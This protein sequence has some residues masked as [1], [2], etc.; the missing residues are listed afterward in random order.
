MLKQQ[1]IVKKSK[2]GKKGKKYLDSSSG[3]KSIQYSWY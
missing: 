2:S 3:N 1:F